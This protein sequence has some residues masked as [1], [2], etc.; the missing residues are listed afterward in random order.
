MKLT[1]GVNFINIIWAAFMC[2]DPKS[3]KYTDNLTVLFALLGS[4]HEKAL[5]KMLIKLTPGSKQLDIN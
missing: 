5:G 4:M 3:T 2:T 1:P